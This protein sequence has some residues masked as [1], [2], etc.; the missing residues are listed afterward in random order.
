M[1][2]DTFYHVS[3]TEETNNLPIGGSTNQVLAK[4]NGDDFNVY[5]KDDTV[6]TG[7]PIGGAVGQVLT[8]VSVTDFDANW[9]TPATITLGPFTVNGVAVANATDDLTTLS[10]LGTTTKV[11][12]GNASGT[13]TWAAVSLSSDVTGNLPVTNLNSG[14]GASSTTYWR[15]DGTW[16]TPSG[17]GGSVTDYPM[18]QNFAHNSEFLYSD[19]SYSSVTFANGGWSEHCFR[20]WGW[21]T[22]PDLYTTIANAEDTPGIAIKRTDINTTDTFYLVQVFDSADSVKFQGRTM[23]LTAVVLADV[24]LDELYLSIIYGSGLNESFSE[25]ADSTWTSA[26]E[27]V[28][29]NFGP[30]LSAGYSAITLMADIDT[31]CTQLA[32]RIHG[33]FTSGEGST[34]SNIHIRGVYL[35]D[36]WAGTNLRM[37]TKSMAVVQHECCRY[38]RSSKLYLRDSYESHLIDMRAIPIITATPTISTTGT[39]SDTLVIKVNSSG[40][41]GVHT[42]RLDCELVG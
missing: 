33:T 16:S 38:I 42:V 23:H 41:N 24:S 6:G 26:V 17:G 35:T 14:T 39:T 31:E 2:F 27:E 32:I 13:P 7:L 4:V 19:S 10:D 34:S 3:P 1:G 8:K 5:W 15:G 20:W 29:T 28:S 11:L 22:G 37:D 12:H 9:Q 40:D 30:G 25:G 36:E 21:A 18:P